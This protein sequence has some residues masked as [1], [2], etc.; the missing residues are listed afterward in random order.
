MLL[1]GGI[2]AHE[3]VAEKGSQKLAWPDD[4][5]SIVMGTGYRGTIEQLAPPDRARV[6]EQ[7]ISYIRREAITEVETRVVH[8]LADKP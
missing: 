5:W 1:E 8:A 3:V 2:T 7:N 4:L 6:R